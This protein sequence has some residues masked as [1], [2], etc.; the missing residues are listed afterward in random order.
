MTGQFNRSRSV[1]SA[2]EYRLLFAFCFPLF[3]ASTCL[4]ALMPIGR[5]P[6]IDEERASLLARARRS[7][8]A[9]LPFAFMG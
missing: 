4:T 2:W 1:A 7:A 9:T 5:R 8:G 6:F 3:L